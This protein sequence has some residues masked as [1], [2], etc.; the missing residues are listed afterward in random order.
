MSY[1]VSHETCVTTTRQK[2]LL[3]AIFVGIPE[4]DTPINISC[5]TS[6]FLRQKISLVLDPQCLEVVSCNIENTKTWANSHEIIHTATNSTPTTNVIIV[7]RGYAL[8]Q[9]CQFSIVLLYSFLESSYSIYK[10]KL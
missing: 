8:S 2:S 5:L 1:L 9:T 10:K 3:L 6:L 7:T 4:T